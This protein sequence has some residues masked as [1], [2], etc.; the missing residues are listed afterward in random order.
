MFCEQFLSILPEDIWVAVIE[1]QA[2]LPGTIFRPAQCLSEKR[3]PQKVQ[4]LPIN[5]QVHGIV[6]F[7]LSSAHNAITTGIGLAN[8]PHKEESAVIF[9]LIDSRT[10]SQCKSEKWK[11]YRCNGKGH[12]AYQCPQHSS[13]YCDNGSERTASKTTTIKLG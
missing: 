4:V 10:T 7:P 8:A 3:I 1:R 9:N 11:C 6:L 5:L 13:H 12:L 2:R